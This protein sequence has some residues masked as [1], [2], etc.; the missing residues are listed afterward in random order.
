MLSHFLYLYLTSAVHSSLTGREF[1]CNFQT[2]VETEQLILYSV[3]SKAC[4]VKITNIV[5][6]QFM[7]EKWHG[8]ESET[9]AGR[10]DNKNNAK[11]KCCSFPNCHFLVHKTC[12]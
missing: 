9:V 10:C 12:L 8:E 11:H 2:L 4:L 3:R 1:L 6:S 5:S 7:E